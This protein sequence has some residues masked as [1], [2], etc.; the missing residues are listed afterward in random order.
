VLQRAAG[1]GVSATLTVDPSKVGLRR[2]DRYRRS[3]EGLFIRAEDGTTVPMR[4]SQS[5]EILWNHVAPKLDAGDKLWFVCLK[6]RQVY[7]STFWCALSFI[8]TL[9]RPGTHSLVLAHDL[10]T[11]HELFSKVRTFYEHLPLPKLRAPRMNELT[12]PFPGGTSKYRVISAGSVAKGRGTTQSAMIL[13]EL[14]SWPHPDIATGL[15]QAIPDLPDTMLVEES[16]ARGK[17]GPGRLFYDEWNRAVRGDSD[18]EP[19]FIPWFAMK[20]YRRQPAVPEGDWDESEQLLSITYG[21][22]DGLS[23][24]PDKARLVNTEII[25]EQLA[26]RRYAIKTTC[27]N[28]V[29][30]FDQEYPESPM[31]AF[32]ATGQPAFDR[33]ALKK[34]QANICPPIA[35]MGM[36]GTK[37]VER[38]RGELRIW[39]QPEADTEYVIGADTAEG[40]A[41]GDYAAAEILNCRTLEQVGSIH[42]TIPPYEFAHL[43]NATGRYFNKAILCVEVWPSGH[44]VQDHLIRELYY[45]RLHPWKG[46]PD[47]IRRT[48]AFLYGWATNVWSRP[49]M[50]GAGQRAINHNLITIHEDGLLEELTDFSKNDHGKYEAEVGHDDRV[51]ALLLALRSREENY[52]ERRAGPALSTEME[53]LPTSIR[54]VEAREPAADA[55]RRLSKLLRQKASQAAKNWLQY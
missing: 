8:R 28:S 47:H 51:M 43:L 39:K 54:V 29:D 9:E 27:Q 24:F 23:Q 33:H 49:L 44:R 3:M 25:G 52:V 10:F 45:P 50:V 30:N 31:V 13:S 32:I 14:P 11:S 42:G 5:Q 40:I 4:F 12:F 36:E 1:E 18:L 38:S 41:G 22:P 20:K 6:S 55:K 26:W 35:V 7:S 37:L 34:Q 15:L 16:T 19:I 46:K 48:P 17:V 21:G 53:G 2:S